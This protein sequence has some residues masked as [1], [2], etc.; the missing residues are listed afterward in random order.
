MGDVCLASSKQNPH[1]SPEKYNTNFSVPYYSTH[2][3]HQSDKL[4]FNR[5]LRF[6]HAMSHIQQEKAIDEFKHLVPCVSVN[7][8]LLN[9][10]KYI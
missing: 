7:N 4:I 9:R 2:H 8:S 10:E 1:C 5:I 3:S 6:L